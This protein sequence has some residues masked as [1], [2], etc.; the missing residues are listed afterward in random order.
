MH[1]SPPQKLTAFFSR[2]RLCIGGTKVDNH[3]RTNCLALVWRTSI[4][5]FTNVPVLILRSPRLASLSL[6]LSFLLSLFSSLS[7]SISPRTCIRISFLPRL[8]P[9]FSPTP[10]RTF[11]FRWACPLS[12]HPPRT[13]CA[14][15]LRG[16]LFNRACARVENFKFHIRHVPL[17]HTCN[18]T[19][20][21]STNLSDIKSRSSSAP[22]HRER[23]ADATSETKSRRRI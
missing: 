5:T 16:S 11:L 3:C 19:R 8:S 2:F 13:E 7:H 4:Y 14:A 18:S 21:E 15:S 20:E 17:P 22:R 6:S 10:A 1:S 9:P 12:R 23:E